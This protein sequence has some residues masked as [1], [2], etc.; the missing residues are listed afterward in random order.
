LPCCSRRRARSRSQP[1][2]ASAR[3]TLGDSAIGTGNT[4]QCVIGGPLPDPCVLPS[5]AFSFFAF[6]TPGGGGFGLYTHRTAAGTIV[7]AVVNCIEVVGT[8]AVIGGNTFRTGGVTF[9][10]PWNVWLVDNGP[11]GGPN[12]DL[13]SPFTFD[14]DE[15]PSLLPCA[16]TVSPAGYFPVTSGNIRVTDGTLAGP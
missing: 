3:P 12:P 4:G 6:A 15:P 14:P 1:H 8:S 7:V 13:I 10:E 9:T 16:S 11:L 5:R 2:R